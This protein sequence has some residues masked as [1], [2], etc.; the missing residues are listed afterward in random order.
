MSTARPST[1]VNDFDFTALFLSLLRIAEVITN[2]I[3]FCLQNTAIYATICCSFGWIFCKSFGL[4]PGAKLIP[5]SPANVGK[6]IS[7]RIN[8]I[9]LI[10]TPKKK[11]GRSYYATIV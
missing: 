11:V 10:I 9:V 1:C 3:P 6:V 7:A 8:T 5:L 4:I 2:F